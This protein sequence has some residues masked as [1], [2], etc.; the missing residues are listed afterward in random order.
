MKRYFVLTFFILLASFVTA[1]GQNAKLNDIEYNLSQPQLVLDVGNSGEFDSLFVSDPCV[2][3][4]DGKYLMYY[5][6]YGDD[7]RARIG[8]AESNDGKNWTKKGM[9]LDSGILPDLGVIDLMEP[10]VIIVE[11]PKNNVLKVA[12]GTTIYRMWYSAN[13]HE[14]NFIFYADSHGNR[15]YTVLPLKTNDYKSGDKPNL[16]KIKS[17]IEILGYINYNTVRRILN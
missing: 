5:T 6:G 2:L 9:V 11:A 3:K 14:N 8:L 7:E 10:C 1:E 16:S 13:T 12:K 17:S 15:G 4:V